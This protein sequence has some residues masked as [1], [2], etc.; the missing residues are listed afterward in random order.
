MEQ[1]FQKGFTLIE[2]L[3]VSTIFSILIL[4]GYSMLSSGEATW[5]T[6]D[7][8]IQLQQNLRQT[9]EKVSKELRETSSSQVVS[10]LDGAGVSGSD[11]LR[12]SMPVICHN[13][14]NVMD[15]SGNV[16]HWGAPLTWG[17]TQSSCMHKDNTCSSV[18]YKYIE[19]QINTSNQLLRR[20][21][22]NSGG[23][24]RQDI[25]AQ[26]IKDFQVSLAN[27]V[28]T[29]TVT[30]YRKTDLNRSMTSSNNLSVSLRN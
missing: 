30:A 20:V 5:F 16:A 25:F 10:G 27:N 23:L 17:C 1:K 7:V 11:I 28:L 18:D 15:A 14:D 6:T 19:Y 21:L 4:A 26:N 2:F 9:L 22:N 3:M 12:F 29:M 8:Q 24:V 13:G